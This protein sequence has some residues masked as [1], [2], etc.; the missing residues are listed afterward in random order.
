MVPFYAV[1]TTTGR[2]LLLPLL[3]RLMKLNSSIGRQKTSTMKLSCELRYQRRAMFWPAEPL[4]KT[5]LFFCY[6]LLAKQKKSNVT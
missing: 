1:D 2:P 4:A 6:F 3:I 5:R